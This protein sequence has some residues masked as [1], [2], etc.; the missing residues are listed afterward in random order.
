MQFIPFIGNKKKLCTMITNIDIVAVKYLEWKNEWKWPKLSETAAYYGIPF[1]EC[2]LH[3]SMLDAE[4][5]AKILIM[6]I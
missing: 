2:E 4:L 5:T 3:S 1:N 6:S